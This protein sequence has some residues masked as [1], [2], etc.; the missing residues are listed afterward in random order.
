[1]TFELALTGVCPGVPVSAVKAAT[2]WDLA[3]SASLRE[4]PPPSA[5]ELAALRVLRAATPATEG[6][7]R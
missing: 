1:V 7:S 3:V 4:L 6:A 5:A 2:G